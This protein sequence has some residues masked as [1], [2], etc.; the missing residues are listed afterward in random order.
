MFV[1]VLLLLWVYFNTMTFYNTY[2]FVATQVNLFLTDVP[3]KTNPNTWIRK[4]RFSRFGEEEDEEMVACYWLRRRRVGH[5]YRESSPVH[6][7]DNFPFPCPKHAL[8]WVITQTAALE[9]LNKHSYYRVWQD[10]FTFQNKISW[11]YFV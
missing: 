11:Y 8:C 7:T 9:Y 5:K 1:Y 3:N 10:R 2:I 4:S 6:G